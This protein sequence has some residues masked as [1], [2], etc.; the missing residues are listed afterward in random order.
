MNSHRAKIP[1]GHVKFKVRY[2][3]RITRD[4]VKFAKGMNKT[5]QRK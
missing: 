2:L 5:I 4:K 1:Q 3:I